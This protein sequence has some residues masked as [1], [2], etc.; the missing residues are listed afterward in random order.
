M[1]QERKK[2]IKI[3]TEWQKEKERNLKV[4]I[5]NFFLVMERRGF[6]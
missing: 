4:Y 3:S 2:Q 1:E 6:P 5:L